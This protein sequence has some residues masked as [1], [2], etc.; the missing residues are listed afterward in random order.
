[1]APVI[2]ACQKHGISFF[3]VHTGQHYSYNMDEVFLEELG[4]PPAKYQLEV[5]SGT[6]GQQTAGILPALEQILFEERP[7]VILVQGD[8]N[9]VLAGALASAKSTTRIGHVEAGLRSYDRTMPEEI[10]RVL[11]D[12]V[13]HFLFAPTDISRQNLLREGIVQEN[14]FVTGNTI[15][16]SIQNHVQMAQKKSSVLKRLKLK[17]QHYF[18]LTAHRAENVDYK[19][20]LKGILEGLHRITRFYE[21][22]LVWPIH[23]RTKKNIQTFNL[24]KMFYAIPH[25]RIVDPL[26]FWDFLQLLS[27]SKLVLTDSGGMQEETCILKIP[28]VTLR[29]N[30]ERPETLDVG[31]NILAGTDPER[32]FE[33]VQEML[34]REKIWTQPFGDG[35][36]G[37]QIVEILKRF[38]VNAEKVEGIHLETNSVK[39]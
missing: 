2:R 14:I 16:E 34:S 25:L 23:P 4:L 28:C 5:G 36:T 10:N 26:G 38:S 1:M 35:T 37:D 20:Q 6:H 8:T 27:N 12:H 3:L 29:Q 39:I 15:V 13:S 19:Q 11:T 7:D 22:P 9:T 18:L 33:A 24:E 30:T 32:M 21:T 31:S 17:P